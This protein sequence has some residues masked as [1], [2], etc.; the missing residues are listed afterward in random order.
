MSDGMSE[1]YG[2]GGSNYCDGCARKNR[3][4]AEVRRQSAKTIMEY[5]AEVQK[6]HERW[7][8]LRR[9]I[10][11]DYQ[12]YVYGNVADDPVAVRLNET[13]TLMDDLKEGK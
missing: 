11:A 6:L 5:D 13:L 7:E 2:S 4:I 9:R 1:A 10:E 12:G 8:E 3:E